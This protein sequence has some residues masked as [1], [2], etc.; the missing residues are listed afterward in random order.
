[1][2]HRK[3]HFEIASES[4]LVVIVSLPICRQLPNSW[5]KYVIGVDPGALDCKTW[6]QVA[7][8]SISGS[9]RQQRTRNDSALSHYIVCNSVSKASNTSIENQNRKRRS[10]AAFRITNDRQ[11]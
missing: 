5:Q 2:L 7:R 8:V 1:M 4:G 11:P 3:G 10:I 9:R 6:E